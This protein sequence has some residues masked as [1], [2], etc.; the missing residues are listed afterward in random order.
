MMIPGKFICIL[1]AIICFAIKGLNISIGQIDMMNI[2][3]AALSLSLI[4]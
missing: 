2:G 1:V 3:F 4:I